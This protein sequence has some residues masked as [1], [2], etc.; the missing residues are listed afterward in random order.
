MLFVRRN[1]IQVFIPK[2]G[3]EVTLYLKPSGGAKGE[4]SVFTFNEEVSYK[5]VLR[6]DQP[7]PAPDDPLPSSKS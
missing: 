4:K 7:P 1:A 6:C 2:Y 3:L 5:I